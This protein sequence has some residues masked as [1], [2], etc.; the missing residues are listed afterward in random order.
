MRKVGDGS[1]FRVW[2][3]RAFVRDTSA[4]KLSA[5][6]IPRVFL[7]FVPEA[8]EWQF[9]HPTS[10]R[11][12][13]S[14]DVT[15]DESVL[16][17]RLFPYRSAPLPPPPLFLA[18]G[19]PPVDPLHPQG[20]APS[21]VSLVDPPLLLCL[22]EGVE[23][24]GAKSEGA[25]SGG[26]EP[27]GAASS[28][29]TGVGGGGVTPQAGGPGGTVAVGPRVART[30]GAGAAG[31]RGVWGAGAGDPIDPGAAGA[32]GSGAGGT[33]A[34]GA[35]VGGTGAGGPGVGRT[36][37]GGAAGGGGVADDLGGTVQPRPYFVPLLQH[38]L[39]VPSS[40]SLITPLLCPPPDQSQ[41]ALQPASP[42]P[43]PS[44]YTEQSGDL[45]ARREIASRPVSLV[46]TTSRVPRSRPT[47]VPGTHAMELRPSSVPMRV[48]LPTAPKFSHP[49]V[50]DPESD[51]T[52]AASPTVSRLLATASVP[53]SPPFIGGEC[54]LGTN[55]LEDRQEDFECLAAA[56]P[57]FASMLLALEGDP[58]ASDIPTLRSYAKA[59]VDPYSSQWQAAMDAEMA[60]WKSIGTY[61]DEVPSLGANIVDG[62][63]IF[64][65]KRPPG[66]PPAFKAHYVA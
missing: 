6:A 7:G 50:P 21:G 23:P 61:V 2:G 58:E 44:P 37:V 45:T 4:D 12:L 16:F 17:Y 65:V 34:G 29:A 32:G 42:V 46:R 52:R 38:V 8:P 24:G 9:Y 18:P 26:A 15:F 28:G 66:S 5:R 22:L 11:V 53:A 64:R 35:G 10:R 20:P 1:V 54:A 27:E 60:S 48:P 56:V 41:L 14:Q 62:M 25:E 49:E 39:G 3:S 55:V 40:T 13:P 36:G 33:K 47:L 30:R 31:T 57:H 51:R 43:A 19:S 59:I 63:W